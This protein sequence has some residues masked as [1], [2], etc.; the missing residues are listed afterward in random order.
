MD[1]FNFAQPAP[2][3]AEPAILTRNIVLQKYVIALRH[4]RNIAEKSFRVRPLYFDNYLL[5]QYFQQRST[6]E[7]DDDLNIRNYSNH[8]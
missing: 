6:M 4:F 2:A 5:W 8:F 3:V 7:V 1:E